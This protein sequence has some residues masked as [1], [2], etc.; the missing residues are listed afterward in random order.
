MQIGLMSMLM[1]LPLVGGAA[2]EQDAA[3][4]DQG[5]FQDMMTQQPSATTLMQASPMVNKPDSF[6]PMPLLITAANQDD[7]QDRQD[8]NNSVLEMMGAPSEVDMALAPAPV[9]VAP[10]LVKSLPE[11]HDADAL[12]VPEMDGADEM[13]SASMPATYTAVTPKII[14][15]DAVVPTADTDIAPYPM[16][17]SEPMVVASPV[18]T[19]AVPAIEAGDLPISVPVEAV[20]TVPDAGDSVMVTV[21]VSDA[22]VAPVMQQVAA[23]S[24][25]GVKIARHVA[26]PVAP[27]VLPAEMET[28]I[29]ARGDAA[30]SAAPVE[31]ADFDALVDDM[32]QRIVDGRHAPAKEAAAQPQSSAVA[33]LQAAVA[34][35]MDISSN[36]A[37]AFTD[38]TTIVQASQPLPQAQAPAERPIA[39]P[40]IHANAHGAHDKSPV[41]EQVYVSIR[42]AAKSGLDQ[43]T[44]QLDPADLGRVDVRMDVGKDGRATLMVAAENR[45]TLALLQRDAR[46]LEQLLQQSGIQADAGTMQFHL[47]GGQQQGGQGQQG[48]GFG[49]ALAGA[50]GSAEVETTSHYTDMNTYTLSVDQG[51]DIKV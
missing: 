4:L 16:P 32:I 25:D 27:D 2:P 41:A 6:F 48:E 7:E 29:P 10:A 5:A 8:A 50:E 18:G 42:H 44:I 46:G 23:M 13:A 35:S 14:A 1:R 24:D 26:K 33:Q 22:P 36:P 3:L 9:T 40:L 15:P 28:P 49:N 39:L 11:T 30:K 37:P 17:S 12:V 43:I 51:L 19:D 38:D 47:K 31:D 21:P 45:D 20:Q 34:R